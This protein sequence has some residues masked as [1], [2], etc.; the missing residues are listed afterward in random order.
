VLRF[1]EPTAEIGRIIEE[2]QIGLCADH[3]RAHRS[4]RMLLGSVGGTDP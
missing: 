3:P 1:G 2:D 4:A